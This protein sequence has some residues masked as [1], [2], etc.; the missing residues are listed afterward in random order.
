MNHHPLV[1]VIMPVYNAVPFLYKAVDSI[2]CQSYPHFE[3][4]IV[5]DCS[6]DTSEAIVQSFNDERIVYKPLSENRGVVLAMNEGLQMAKGKYVAVMHADDIALPHRFEMQVK[7]LEK[8]ASTAVLA[9]LTKFIDEHDEPTGYGWAADEITITPLAI[10]TTMR[11]ENCISHPTVMM[12]AEVVKEFGYTS[13]PVHKNFS[14]EDYPLWLRILSAGYVIN[15][16]PEIVL[17]YRVHKNSATG[18]HLKKS[19]PFYINYT[20]KKFYLAQKKK[21][22]PLNEFDKKVSR[23]MRADLLKAGMKNLKNRIQSA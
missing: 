10:R 16:L 20:T 9:G 23:S 4:I 5:N 6:S 22:G 11:R 19:N 15:K 17:L 14:V 7:Y 12:R 2:L 1:S 18:V 21:A 3:L 13:S 8:N